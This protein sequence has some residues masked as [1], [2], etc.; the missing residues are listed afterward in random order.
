ML[1]PVTMSLA[2]ACALIT[3]WLMM[4][5]G[6][7]RVQRKILHGDGGDPL[8]MQRMRAQLNFV[9]SAPF[10]L[11]LV[12]LVEL[13]DKGGKWLPFVAGIYVIGRILHPLGMD[14]ADSNWLRGAGV[15]ITMLTLVGMAVY[16]ALVG[17]GVL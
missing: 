16:A 2:A 5:C 15:G 11:A 14:R 9:E 12:A 3:F 6:Q 8:M 1:L 7:T 10:V 13:A 4:R 17:A